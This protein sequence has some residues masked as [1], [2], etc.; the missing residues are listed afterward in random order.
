M[1][2]T[3]GPWWQTCPS[4]APAIAGGEFASRDF[5]EVKYR[6]AVIPTGIAIYE[7]C[8]SYVLSALSAGRCL[9]AKPNP[10]HRQLWQPPTC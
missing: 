4:A 3:Y 1:V 8:V 2:R 7:T 6:T 9:L 10:C 5:L